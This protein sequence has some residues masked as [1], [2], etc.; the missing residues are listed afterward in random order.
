M[1]NLKQLL[2]ACAFALGCIVPLAAQ[3]VVTGRITDAET[4]APIVGASVRVERTLTGATSDNRGEFR[5]ADAAPD[6]TIRV[7]HVSYEARTV[8]LD[9]RTSGLEIALQPSQLNIAQVVVTGTGTHR[10]LD[11][12][13]VPVTILTGKELQEGVMTNLEDALLKSDPSFAITPLGSMG[14]AITMNGLDDT[15][16]LFLVNGQRMLGSG[17]GAPDLSRIDMANVKRIEILDGAASMLYGSDAIAGVVNI[18]TDEPRSGVE[19]S[20]RAS[21]RNHGR[22]EHSVNLDAKE[23]KLGIYTSFVHQQADGWRLNPF[24]EDKEGALIPS[25]RMASFATA[26]NTVSQRFTY[27][28]ARGL[29][30]YA[31]GSYYRYDQHRPLLIDDQATTYT[32]DLGHRNYTYGAGLKYIVNDRVSLFAD[33]HSDNYKST[34]EYIAASGDL[35]PGDT[36]TRIETRF[37]QA[38]L[39]GIFKIDRYNRLSA[40][41]EYLDDKLDDYLST[42]ATLATAVGNYSLSA[43]LQDELTISRN[44]QAL[45]GLRYLFHERMGSHVTP[46][47]ALMYHTG[48]FKA[49]AS[50]AAGYK[51]PALSEIYTFNVS[52]DGALTIGNE[53]LRPEKSHYTSLNLEY[54]TGRFNFSATGFYNRLTDKVEVETFEVSDEELRHYQSIYGDGITQHLVKKR[55]NI[56]KARIAGLT[57]SAKAYV[58]AGF[59]LRAAYNFI[60]GVNLSAPEGEEDRLDKSIRHAGNVS[61][62]WEHAWNKYT[63]HIE[64]NGRISGDRFS[65]TYSPRIGDAPGYSLWDLVTT[66]TF[67]L[68]RVILTPS[69]GVENLFNFRDDRPAYLHYTNASGKAAT[70]MSPYA[71]LN[72]GR[73]IFFALGIR[74]RSK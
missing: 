66:H 29:S 11:D 24:E 36:E 63:L 74:L 27:D 57:L 69:L 14:S 73:T 39:K 58:G 46:N 32:Y 28:L 15:Y 26:T 18:I 53:D 67:R 56:D 50:Y 65:S 61:A 10:R 51:T 8:A 23:G 70:T 49:R 31:E 47:I 42:S 37:Y 21:L 30:L 20:T 9:G 34:Y 41:L 48:G 13:P 1:K 6:A 35:R 59:T 22:Y 44:W 38:S 33:F 72:P 16:I 64:L 3:Q 19:L 54:G 52:K 71:T 7:S 55:S 40:G 60:D 68:G 17:T 5:I 45:V 4:G 2:M 43:Y 62:D 25:L 12:A